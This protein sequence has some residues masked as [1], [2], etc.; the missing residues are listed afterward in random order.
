MI[1][2]LKTILVALALVGTLN[3][4]AL[5]AFAVA[6][7]DTLSGD[8]CSGLSQLDSSNDCGNGDKGVQ[9][10]I[11]AIVNILSIIIGI[12]AV[13]VLIVGGLKFITSGGDTNAVASAKNTIIYALVGIVVAILA[14]FLIHFVVNHVT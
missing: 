9:S 14:Q 4:A 7:P 1:R 13:I 12:A 8:A 6:G 5:P 2:K 3:L 11:T 10:L